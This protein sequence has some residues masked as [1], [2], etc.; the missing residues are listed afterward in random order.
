MTLPCPCP[1][2]LSLCTGSLATI[3]DIDDETGDLVLRLDRYFPALWECRNV[4][5]M[6]AAEAEIDLI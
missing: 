2:S 4:I 3:L 5:C 1:A 6:S